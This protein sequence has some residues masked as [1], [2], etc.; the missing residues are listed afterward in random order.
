M[1]RKALSLFILWLTASTLTAMEFTS[2]TKADPIVP[3]II[4]MQL[5]YIRSNGDIDPS[6]L[7]IRRLD[8]V[9]V[10]TGDMVNYS[11]EIQRDNVIFDGNG[12]SLTFRPIGK[13]DDPYSPQTADPVIRVLNRDSIII[14]RVTFEPFITGSFTAVGVENSSNVIIMNNTM[15]SLL[16]VSIRLSTQCSVIGNK[17]TNAGVGVG[18]FD[19]KLIN[20]AYN[21]IS[22]RY[23][24]A[25]IGSVSYSNITRNKITDN[26]ETGIL[27]HGSNFNNRI[28][29]NNFINNDIG[30]LYK[31]D[32]NISANDNI[33]NNYWSNNQA[34]IKNTNGNGITYADTAADQSPLASPI[35]TSFD[36]SLFPLPS[37]TPAVSPT[38]SAQSDAKPFPTTLIIASI[39]SVTCVGIGLLLYFKKR[40]R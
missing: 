24:G 23:I 1:K 32:S 25:T 16:G 35:S 29:E 20:L 4:P 26:A 31:G 21:E 13:E 7:P 12:Y 39:A 18:I 40:K 34:N 22:S 37:L 6:T 11:I 28:F 38:P 27:L 9:Y 10:L 33:F 8:N 5:A 19:S 2:L 30:L 14:K 36:P 15:T 3:E 17:I